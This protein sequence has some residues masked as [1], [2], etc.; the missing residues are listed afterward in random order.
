MPA[1]PRPATRPADDETIVV[2][3][4]QQ[5]QQG[6]TESAPKRC[7]GASIAIALV[8]PILVAA[9][10]SAGFD[11]IDQPDPDVDGAQATLSLV[12]VAAA[13]GWGL[14]LLFGRRH[15]LFGL[16]F[17]IIAGVPLAFWILEV[18]DDF[19]PYSDAGGNFLAMTLLGLML[20]GFTIAIAAATRGS[21]ATLSAI[22]YGTASAYFMGFLI[23]AIGL[24]ATIESKADAARTAWERDTPGLG[25]LLILAVLMV[26][27][28]VRQRIQKE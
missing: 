20:Y 10:Y 1:A 16:L 25:A 18:S 28:V 3:V 5:Q 15:G 17:G 12:L 21:Y 26:L 9:L 13:I 24:L 11:Q 14:I 22:G 4:Q 27:A 6:G 7:S 2:V 23:A 8:A 19:G